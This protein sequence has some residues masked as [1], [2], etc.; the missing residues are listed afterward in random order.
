MLVFAQMA[1]AA[2]ACTI[3]PIGYGSDH[4]NAGFV[5]EPAIAALDGRSTDVMP[6]DSTP[7]A[8][9]VSHCRSGQQHVEAKPLPALPVAP[10]A[11]VAA[12]H[13]IEPLAQGI[14]VAATVPIVAR[15]LP[16]AQP[17]LTILHCCWRI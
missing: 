15:L 3:T 9:C 2:Y 13:A 7:S 17:P 16:Q 4:P 1:V 11:L 5:D 12:A 6:M 10:V 14:R 8:L